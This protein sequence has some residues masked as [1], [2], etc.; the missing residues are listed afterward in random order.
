MSKDLRNTYYH[1]DPRM[2]CIAP[3]HPDFS[4]S[5]IQ[6]RDD[7]RERLNRTHVSHLN[8]VFHKV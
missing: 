7:V 1:G 8:G 6:V 2:G 4:S 3:R 5:E